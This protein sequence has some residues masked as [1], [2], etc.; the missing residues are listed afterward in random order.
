[1]AARSWAGNREFV[2]NGYRV[3][4]WKDESPGDGWW[5]W[6]PDSMNKLNNTELS[7]KNE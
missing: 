2:F 5:G 4:L 1:M 6:L 7:L 3:P